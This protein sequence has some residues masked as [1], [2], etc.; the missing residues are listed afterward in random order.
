[1]KLSQQFW[2]TPKPQDFEAE[3]VE[4]FFKKNPIVDSLF[5]NPPGTLRTN[6][7]EP[8]S[9]STMRYRAL[10]LKWWLWKAQYCRPVYWQC[11]LCFLRALAARIRQDILQSVYDGSQTSGGEALLKAQF[12]QS[13]P[14]MTRQVTCGGHTAKSCSHCP[15]GANSASLG[16]CWFLLNFHFVS[17]LFPCFLILSLKICAACRSLCMPVHCPLQVPLNMKRSATERPWGKLV[18]PRLW[19]GHSLRARVHYSTLHISTFRHCE[20]FRTCS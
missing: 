18:Q 13:R 19:L 8:G 15:Q 9:Q 12:R 5:D 16:S 1:M 7:V 6:M 2:N 10:V 17:V 11:T 3:A 20:H 14:G 4:E